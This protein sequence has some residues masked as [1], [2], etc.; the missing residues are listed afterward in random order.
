[1]RCDGEQRLT[2]IATAPRRRETPRYLQVAGELRAEILSGKFAASDAFPT[3]NDLC[4]RYGVSRFTIR[5]ALRR[6][7]NEGLIARRRGSG[8]VVQPA[9]ARGGT[10]H[11]PLSNVGEILQYARDTR[12]S[13]GPRGRGALPRAV[14]DQLGDVAGGDWTAFRGL[15]LHDGDAPPIAV[16]DAYFHEM[17]DDAVGQ[18]DLAAGPLFSQ[19]ER[20]AGMSVGRVTQD[21]KAIAAS[22][23][24]AG[25]LDVKRG[26]PI[27]QITRCYFDT[28][29]QLFEISV[30]HHPGDRFAYSMHID[31]DG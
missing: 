18:F 19:I 30:S 16:T 26:S 11:Q 6:L 9:S 14:V 20:L 10:L 3:E 31:V 1:M 4:L 22:T 24:I 2:N 8:T 28:Q 29:G 12:V 7:Q 15:R 13:Y 27:L 25:A 5:E 23:D 17:L 21:I